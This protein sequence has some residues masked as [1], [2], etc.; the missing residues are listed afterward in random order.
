MNEQ[1]HRNQ[2][3]LFSLLTQLLVICCVVIAIFAVVGYTAG[4]ITWQYDRQTET[5]TI[6][7]E[8]GEVKKAA[9]E[10]VEKGK[11]LIDKTGDE[12]KKLNEAP[13]ESENAPLLKDQPSEQTDPD[14][15]TTVDPDE[16]S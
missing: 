13:P 15:E 5:S 16:K 9:E 3:G 1:R 6:E 7:I 4:W 10:T 11:A 12:I 14:V 2:P 8:T